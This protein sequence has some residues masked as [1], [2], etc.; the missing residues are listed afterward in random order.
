MS[1]S[2][3]V[4]LIYTPEVTAGTTPVDATWQALRFTSE[5]INTEIS[6]T[7]SEELRTD[8]QTSGSTITSGTTGG[9]IDVEVSPDSFDDFIEAVMGGN[10]AADVLEI[11]TTDHSFSVQKEFAS[12]AAAEKYILFNGMR[13]SQFEM[14][15]EYGNQV[16]G[17]FT[18]AGQ[19]SA[20][21]A[22]DAVGAGSVTP[23]TTTQVFN[24]SA[25]VTGLKIDDVASDACISNLSLTLNGNHRARTCLGSLYPKGQIQG[26][27]DVTGSIQIYAEDLEFEKRKINGD[28][29]K[30]EFTV[31]NAD[32]SYTFVFPKVRIGGDTPT[33]E[34]RNSDVTTGGDFTAHA[35]DAG[36]SALTITRA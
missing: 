31:G 35:G 2:N 26:S 5:S 15:A 11:G 34:G 21:T 32:G 29:I 36:E 3:Q 6:E 10:W 16:T 8:R 18:I 22:T 20:V 4:S 17:S 19:D 12:F 30:L 13:V 23:R 28:Y 33:A 24:A 27:L 1:D 25:D 7:V 9:G 14:S